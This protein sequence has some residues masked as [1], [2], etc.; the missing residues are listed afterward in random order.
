MTINEGISSDPASHKLT[1]Q[2]HLKMYDTLPT[3]K[4]FGLLVDFYYK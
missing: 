1:N 2:L 3:N 4:A